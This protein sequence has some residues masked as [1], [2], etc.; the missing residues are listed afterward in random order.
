MTKVRD[1][2]RYHNGLVLVPLS[3]A[4]AHP[5]RLALGLLRCYIGCWLLGG[6]KGVR[7]VSGV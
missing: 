7:A 5:K 6:G 2:K 4:F 1:R 3:E